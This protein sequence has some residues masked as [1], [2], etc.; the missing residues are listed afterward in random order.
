MNKLKQILTL[1]SC[2]L[3]LSATAIQKEGQIFAYNISNIWEK[4][5]QQSPQDSIPQD[6]S[7]KEG[8][9]TIVNTS[10]LGKDV[11]GYANQVP[12]LIFIKD[13]KIINIKALQNDETPS[14]FKRASKLFTKWIGLGT[15]EAKNLKV[16]VVSGATFTSDAIIQNVHLALDLF[17][18]QEAISKKKA[19]ISKKL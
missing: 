1:L 2:I 16:D 11:Y 5:I 13:N 15:Q 19:L 6:I 17:H 18:K 12:L 3:I 9:I 14:F 4:E 7:F 8:G 10:L